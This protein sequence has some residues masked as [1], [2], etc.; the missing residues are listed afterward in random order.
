MRILFVKLLN[1]MLKITILFFGLVYIRRLLAYGPI[2][3][4]KK[5]H[6]YKKHVFHV[7]I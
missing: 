3:L 4:R 5:K 2:N 6:Y 7:I 1:K